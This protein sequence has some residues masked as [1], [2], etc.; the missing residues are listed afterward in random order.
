PAPWQIEAFCQKLSR[1]GHCFPSLGKQYQM[2][3]EAVRLFNESDYREHPT[4]YFSKA[5]SGP[6]KWKGLV[7]DQDKQYVEVGIG[8]GASSSSDWSEANVITDPHE[9]AE[10]IAAGVIPLT[11]VKGF[12]QSGREKRSVAMALSSCQPLYDS[13][14]R[15]RFPE[16]SL[17]D[18]HWFAI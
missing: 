16:S 1:S 4:M 2:R 11:E 8:L 17:F 13:I 6:E 7:V 15:E 9:Y 5:S 10:A 12:N 14:H 18:N 3:E